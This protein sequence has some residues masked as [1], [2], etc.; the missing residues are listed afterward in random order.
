ML[1]FYW[2]SAQKNTHYI[3]IFIFVFKAAEALARDNNMV[4]RR[5]CL[6]LRS[7]SSFALMVIGIVFVGAVLIYHS[8][9]SSGLSSHD[10]SLSSRERKKLLRY[11][12][13]HPKDSFHTIKRKFKPGVP[14]VLPT[15][16]TAQNLGIKDIQDILSLLYPSDW[17]IT[18]EPDEAAIILKD[19]LLDLN[20]QSP[21]SCRDIDDH[22]IIGNIGSSNKKF[23][24]QLQK[25]EVFG[26]FNGYNQNNHRNEEKRMVLKSQGKDMQTKITCMKTVY[27]ADFCGPMG[28]YI[29]MRE[30]FLFSFLRHPGLVNIL[31]YCLRGDHISMDIRKKGLMLVMEPGVP[32]TSGMV[33]SLPWAHRV[34]VGVCE[35]FILIIFCPI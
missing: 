1:L 6:R 4:C 3:Y 27:N 19:K 26:G 23:V 30:I 10:N 24:E 7:R 35:V 31:G 33:T 32:L 9:N 34:Q 12:P 14:R 21:L 22:Q 28:N 17:K 16:G 29:L 13:A 8:L 20:L 25:T 15:G 5:R 2:I 18:L 11:Q